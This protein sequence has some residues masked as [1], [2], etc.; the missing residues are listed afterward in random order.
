MI[1]NLQR[2]PFAL[3]VLVFLVS[4]LALMGQSTL[5]TILG[6]VRDTSGSAVPKV[7]IKLR[8]LGTNITVQVVSNEL[9]YYELPLLQAGMYEVTA[10]APG[11]KMFKQ[12]DVELATSRTVR[13]DVALEV[14]AVSEQV[15]VTAEAGTIETERP[16]ITSSR[17]AE[18][19]RTVPLNYIGNIS[20]VIRQFATVPGAQPIRIG[21]SYAVAGVRTNANQFQMD[22]VT[23]PKRGS[24]MNTENEINFEGQEEFRLVSVNATAEYVSPATFQQTS[25]A[26]SNQFHVSADYRGTIPNL[27][28]R[29]WFQ[30]ARVPRHRIFTVD[31]CQDRL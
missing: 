25:R 4:A 22:G 11:F 8:N 23:P 19:L 10:E 12:S 7:T 2:R 9:G 30:P 6:N 29:E 26:G 15:T 18:Q 5:G 1:L 13:V 14:G 20:N 16:T 3:G 31:G 21:L 24:G 28:A 17:N 27:V